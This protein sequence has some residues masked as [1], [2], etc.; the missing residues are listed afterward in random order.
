MTGRTE[1]FKDAEMDGWSDSCRR[2]QSQGRTFGHKLAATVAGPQAKKN[3]AL[4]QFNLQPRRSQSTR[5]F[6][7][8]SSSR[9]STQLPPHP[10]HQISSAPPRPYQSLVYVQICQRLL[11]RHYTLSGAAAALYIIC[12]INMNYAS[13]LRARLRT[14]SPCGLSIL[15]AGSRAEGRMLMDIYLPADSRL[16]FILRLSLIVMFSHR[17]RTHGQMYGRGS[18]V[19]SGLRRGR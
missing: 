15:C 1:W 19:T 6:P 7:A 4:I 11:L 2:K 5:N 12:H 17:P 13:L 8:A 14:A 3:C 9:T 18:W 10:P 16:R